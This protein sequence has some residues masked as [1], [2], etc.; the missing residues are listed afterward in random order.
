MK[1][2]TQLY[3]NSHNE[4]QPSV[5]VEGDDKHQV[6]QETTDL[7]IMLRQQ[8]ESAGLKLVSDK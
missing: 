1:Y 8:C 3:T 5:E 2:K 6:V 7:L 4:I